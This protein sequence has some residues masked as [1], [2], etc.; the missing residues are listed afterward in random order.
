MWYIIGFINKVSTYFFDQL[1]LNKTIIYKQAIFYNVV[2]NP[3]DMKR[4]GHP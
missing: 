1:T 4:S 2:K 3:N